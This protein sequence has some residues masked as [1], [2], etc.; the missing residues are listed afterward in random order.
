MMARHKENNIS[1]RMRFAP[2]GL[3]C[4][5]QGVGSSPRP[6][7]LSRLFFTINAHVLLF[8]LAFF[9]SGR[10]VLG[11]LLRR[12]FLW[13]RCTYAASRES[14]RCCAARRI[15]TL[16]KYRIRQVFFTHVG[17]VPV[18]PP[19]VFNAYFFERQGRVVTSFMSPKPELTAAAIARRIEQR[20]GDPR[21]PGMEEACCL[22]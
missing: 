11:V 4:A 18:S 10:P 9:C 8:S 1:T 12:L 3:L 5:A 17:N 22:S 13:R 16:G 21:P 14:P 19:L 2:T 20:L 15:C 6:L 7:P